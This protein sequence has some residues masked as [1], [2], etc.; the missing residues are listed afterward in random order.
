LWELLSHKTPKVGTKEKTGG[1]KIALVLAYMNKLMFLL[2]LSLLTSYL[3][4]Q[5][6]DLH[7]TQEIAKRL[8]A[9]G[10]LFTVQLV[11]GAKTLDVFVVGYKTAGLKFNDLGMEAF[12]NIGGKSVRLTVYKESDHFRIDRTFKSAHSVDVKLKDKAKEDTLHF[13]IP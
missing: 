2:I 8:E 9:Q 11:P 6:D 7:D 4:A 12:A 1:I 10:K 13:E 5:T 3:H